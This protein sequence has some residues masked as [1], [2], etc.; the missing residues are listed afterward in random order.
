MQVVGVHV[1]DTE[2]GAQAWLTGLGG[3]FSAV[4]DDG[5]FTIFSSYA[6]SDFHV[7]HLYI[8]DRN[9]IIQKDILGGILEAALEGHL[10]DVIYMRDAVNIEMV[11]DVSDTMNYP[12]PGS[13]GDPKLTLMQQ[14]ACM[15]TDFLHDHG[16]AQ[17]EMGLVW[18]TDDASEYTEPGNKKFFEVQTHTATLEDQ[19]NLHTTGTCTAMGAGLQKAYDTLMGKPDHRFAILCTDGMQNIDPKVTEVAGHYEIR[20]AAGWIC[21]PHAADPGHPGVNITTY[22]TRVHTIGI[23][24]TAAYSPVLQAVANQT[25]GFYLGTDAPAVDLDLI[26]FVDLCN[27]L[28]GGSPSIVCH[29]TGRLNA[30]EKFAYAYFSLNRTARKLT[31]MLSW[32]AAQQGHLTF[33]LHGPD[34]QHVDFD[35][36]FKQHGTYAI[37]TVYLPRKAGGQELPHVGQWRVVI[38]GDVPGAYADFHLTAVAED[39]DLHFH[40][41]FP[42]KIY[43]VGDIFPV[44]VELLEGKKWLT[45]LTDLSLEVAHLRTPLA[46]LMSEYRISALEVNR[47]LG[48]LTGALKDPIALKLEAMALDPSLA[49]SLQPLRQVL[50]LRAGKLK[51]VIGEQSIVIPYLLGQAGLHTFKVRILTESPENGP[52][53]RVSMVS[54][55]VEPGAAD[56]KQSQVVPTEIVHGRQKG[57]LFRVTPRNS[58]GQLL[59]PGYGDRISARAGEEALE[60]KAHD[61][62]DGSYELEVLL[63]AKKWAAAKGKGPALKLLFDGQPLWG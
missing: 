1:S 17:D 46:E 59:G 12:A 43:A 58:R 6:G 50:T 33:W 18:F 60:I 30:A 38:T 62:L 23:G 31:V 13:V 4:Q 63:A 7:P 45:R 29:E 42:R 39:R 35:G 9:M 3:T 22:N 24:I 20:D 47:R 28:A 8:I 34:G 15:I 36:G 10:L 54:V 41:D 55:L 32:Q 26:Y 27:C 14:A 52:I 53:E 57:F 40:V 48:R 19:I 5:A 16:Q 11:M 51:P 61:M 56:P 2:A 21:G 49:Q 37:G 44:Q 25:G